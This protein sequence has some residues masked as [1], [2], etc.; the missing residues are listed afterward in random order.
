M[1][2]IVDSSQTVSKQGQVERFILCGP[3]SQTVNGAGCVMRYESEV[4]TAS[5]S[6]T[7]WETI[8]G[9]DA[10]VVSKKSPSEICLSF[11]N[12]IKSFPIVY[13]YGTWSL[14][15]KCTEQNV[16]I[17]SPAPA[18]TP[19]AG[20]FPNLSQNLKLTYGGVDMTNIVDFSQTVSKQGQ[21][22]RFI[23]CG[24]FSQTANGAGCVMRY[25]SEVKTASL[26]ETKWETIIGS[27]AYVV[28][29]K[30]PSEICLSFENPFKSFPII[31]Q[32]G[33]WSLKFKCTEQNV[34]IPSPA[35]LPKAGEFPNLNQNLKLTYKGVDM[36]NIVD[37]SQTVSKQGQVERFI[38]CGPFDQTAN[39]AGCVMRYE[40][41]VKTASLSETKWETIIG[42]DAYVVS[43]KSSSEICLSFENPFKSFPI[44]Y[45]YG[46]WSLK[47]KCTEKNIQNGFL[48]KTQS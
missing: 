11:E 31:Y 39:G 22:E 47:F 25:E 8:I 16:K 12:P 26:S 37:F 36:T 23:L 17:P 30:S 2:Y 38:L 45:Q 42:S 7:Q 24:P 14:K 1:T 18:P 6:E 19:K 20:E 5:L 28:S 15:F 34:K 44:I 41:E 27:D 48:L 40:S 21:V 46:T 10:Y 43:K 13:Q 3:F 9:S 32:Y 33:T 4:K 35:P 29:K